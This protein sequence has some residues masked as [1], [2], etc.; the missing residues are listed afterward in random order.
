MIW[1]LVV[2][3]ALIATVGLVGVSLCVAARKPEPDIIIELSEKEQAL[4]PKL[5]E[6]GAVATTH[7]F[8]VLGS[9]WLDVRAANERDGEEEH[10][11]AE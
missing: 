2:A 11:Q 8:L 4:L 10:D 3:A 1:E 5:I 6:I 9:R 7:P